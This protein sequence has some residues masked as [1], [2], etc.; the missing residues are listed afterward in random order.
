MNREDIYSELRERIPYLQRRMC[1]PRVLDE[2]GVN[3][4]LDK[5][6]EL[7]YLEAFELLQS[8]EVEYKL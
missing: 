7:Q 6:L 5:L 8:E 2:S 1:T 4:L 3:I